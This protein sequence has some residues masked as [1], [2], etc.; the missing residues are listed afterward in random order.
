MQNDPILLEAYA[1]EDLPTDLWTWFDIWLGYERCRIFSGVHY[2]WLNPA[3]AED[4]WHEFLQLVPT[5]F[6]VVVDELWKDPAKMDY[7]ERDPK[8]LKEIQ[9]WPRRASKVLT[10]SH[11]K[12]ETPI[13]L[14]PIL[15]LVAGANG[16]WPTVGFHQPVRRGFIDKSGPT[17]GLPFN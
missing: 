6:A 13:D 10:P 4:V 9:R 12:G 15:A 14:A 8:T 7:I 16:S 3:R 1:P 17:G 2:P 5:I 11:S